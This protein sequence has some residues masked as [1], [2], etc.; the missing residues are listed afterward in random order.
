VLTIPCTCVQ[1]MHQYKLTE[2]DLTAL[3]HEVTT[4]PY[5]SKALPMKLYLVGQLRVSSSITK[6]EVIMH[7]LQLM[8]NRVLA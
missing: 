3:H 8:T 1:Q 6:K 7:V 5:S 4:N 2:K